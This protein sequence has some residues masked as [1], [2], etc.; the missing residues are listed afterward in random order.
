MTDKEGRAVVL[1]DNGYL[2]KILEEDYGKPRIDFLKLSEEICGKFNRLRTYMYD[3]MPYQSNPPTPTER[4]MFG[5]KQ[6][7]F[8]AIQRLPSFE[9]RFGRL[10]PR[11]PGAF[12]QKGV[13]VLL[14]VDL[15]KLSS[16]GQIQK[17]FLVAGDADYVAAV[18]AAKDEGVSITLYYSDKMQTSPDGKSYRKYSSELWEA[19][20]ER[21]VIDEK[22][23]KKSVLSI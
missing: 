18:K 15:V 2:S 1:I 20:D 8:T 11:G 7:F 13:D 16:K 9:I 14:A 4:E 3:C 10:R 23:I 19:C 21:I 6:K 5:N 17:A 12:I 22:L